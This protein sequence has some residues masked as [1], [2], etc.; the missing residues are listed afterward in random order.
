MK[1]KTLILFS[2]LCLV[3]LGYSCNDSDDDDAA[4][5]DMVMSH[6]K[7]LERGAYLVA[8]SGC[9]DCHTPKMMTAQGPAPDMS[10]MLS[11]HPA[12]DSLAPYDKNM[13]GPWVLFSSGLTACV[14]PWGVSY[15]ANLTPSES[16]LKNWTEE[17]FLNCIKN[18]WY[19]GMENGRPLMPPMPWQEI[20]NMTDDDLKS[21]FA[22][23][24]TIPA[25]DNVVPAYEPP[26]GM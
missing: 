12:G 6:E 26:M 25:V 17:Q 10:R 9:N 2:F 19:A 13:I 14:G 8:T 15:A 20:K 4:G 7:M 23:L 11:G 16:G 24:Q 1:K 22:Y 3:W 18:G 5:D 21:I